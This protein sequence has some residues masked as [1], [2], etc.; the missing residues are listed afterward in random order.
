MTCRETSTTMVFCILSLVTRPTSRRF[1]PRAVGVV[2][3]SLIARSPPS[4]VRARSGRVRGRVARV[5]A[6]S[7]CRAG[8]SG[9][10]TG[11]GTAHLAASSPHARAPPPS[12]SRAPWP[13]LEHPLAP[14]D[15]GLDRKLVRREVESLF[16]DVR[17]D[18]STDL[19]ED[20]ARLDERD[21][22]L[23]VALALAHPRLRGLLRD[24]LVGEDADPQLSCALEVTAD[25]DAPRFDLAR[26]QPTTLD[27]LQAPVAVRHRRAAIRDAAH[28]PLL[29]KIGRA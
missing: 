23:R 3:S 4:S 2:V 9:S 14:N 15:A 22:L 20:P 17:L 24:R 1:A 5:G 19:E 7:C 26:G 16:D 10:G 27:R 11:T 18:A 21:P 8:S 12:A 25:G 6:G 13:S 28:L 29:H